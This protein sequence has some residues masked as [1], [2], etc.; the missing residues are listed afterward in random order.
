MISGSTAAGI[1]LLKKM[2]TAVFF[3][4]LTD[5]LHRTITGTIIHAKYFHLL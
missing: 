3:H 4:I 1:F 2:K 5:D